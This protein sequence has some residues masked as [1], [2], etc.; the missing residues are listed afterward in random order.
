M[1]I[2]RLSKCEHSFCSPCRIKVFGNV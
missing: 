1:A 2:G